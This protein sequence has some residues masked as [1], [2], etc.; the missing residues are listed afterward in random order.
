MIRSEHHALFSTLSD[1]YETCD[2]LREFAPLPDD[3]T[4]QNIE[5]H[6]RD[7]SRALQQ[8]TKLQ[9]Q[10]HLA[11]QEA[12]IKASPQMHWR[13][14]YRPDGTSDETN[15]DTGPEPISYDFMEKL[16]VYAIIGDTGPFMSHKMA[17]YMVYMPAGLSYPWH[18]HK[19][20]EFYY[21]LAGEAVFRRAGHPDTTLT[22]GNTLSHSSEM[23]HAMQTYDKPMLSLAVWRTH[24]DKPAYLLD[25]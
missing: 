6:H 11:L 5:P 24:L 2:A 14:V 10:H 1:L 12:L 8:D 25:R 13:E 17:L 4:A 20:E 15:N 21:I 18:A 22:E 7:A 19:A 16:G 3:L 9:S 23:P